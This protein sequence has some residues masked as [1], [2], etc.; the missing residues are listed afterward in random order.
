MVVALPG[1]SAVYVHPKWEGQGLQRALAA[2][3]GRHTL[4]RHKHTPTLSHTQ[5]GISQD[6]FE[7]QY[8]G[9]T[10]MALSEVMGVPARDI[11]FGNGTTTPVAPPPVVPAAAD[12]KDAKVPPPKKPDPPKPKVVEVPKT[13]PPPAPKA[14][15]ATAEKAAKAA[16]QA[17]QVKAAAEG[18]KA[19][20]APTGAGSSYVLGK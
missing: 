10:A 17:A 4:C 11:K 12:K 5:T 7:K 14:D 20:T 6:T 9:K 16:A 1:C 13:L 3:S 19:K 15:P 18:T 2:V 8:A